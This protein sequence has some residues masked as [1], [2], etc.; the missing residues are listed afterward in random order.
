MQLQWENEFG[1]LLKAS[2]LGL[3]HPGKILFPLCTQDDAIV[4]SETPE[5]DLPTLPTASVVPISKPDEG[6]NGE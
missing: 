4:E 5:E 1:K 2:E 6:G 3:R